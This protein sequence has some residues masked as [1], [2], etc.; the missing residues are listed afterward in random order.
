MNR[1]GVGGGVC[2]RGWVNSLRL[3]TALGTALG[4]YDAWERNELDASGFGGRS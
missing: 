2:A 1:G 4:G 3:G